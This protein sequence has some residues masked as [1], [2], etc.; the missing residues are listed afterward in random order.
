MQ[1]SSPRGIIHTVAKAFQNVAFLQSTVK[2]NT[3]LYESVVQQLPS[4]VR[5]EMRN[6]PL[7]SGLLPLEFWRSVDVLFPVLLKGES[8]LGKSTLI[9]SL[10]LTDLY[11][12]RI[13]PGAAGETSAAVS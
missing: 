3:F 5:K 2:T 1:P 4:A 7:T 9:N 8:G 6:C 13:I 12:E 11:P 10:F